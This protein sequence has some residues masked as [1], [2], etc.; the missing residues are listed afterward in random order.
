MGL[1]ASGD[2]FKAKVYD[3]LGDIKGVRRISMM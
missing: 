2:T 3:L 1:C